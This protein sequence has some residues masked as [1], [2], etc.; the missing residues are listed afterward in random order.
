MFIFYTK[1][2][3]AVSRY[4]VEQTQA[5]LA[6]NPGLNAAYIAQMPKMISTLTDLRKLY[7]RP[8]VNMRRAGEHPQSLTDPRYPDGNTDTTIEWLPGE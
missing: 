5:F 6:A 3:E 7:L 2:R 4:G 8:G 1:V